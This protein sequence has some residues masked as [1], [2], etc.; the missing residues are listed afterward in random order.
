[1]VESR[2]ESRVERTVCSDVRMA[3][4]KVVLKDARKVVRMAALLVFDWDASMVDRM[5]WSAIQR[6]MRKCVCVCER[7][8][9]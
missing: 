1:M 9:E 3:V 4:Q 5:V 2:V 6:R 8:C 7:V